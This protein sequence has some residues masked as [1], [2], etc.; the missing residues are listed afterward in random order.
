[1]PKLLSILMPVYNERPYLDRIVSR[2]LQAPLPEGVER[3]LVIVDDGSSDG[4]ADKL[5]ELEGRHPERVRVFHQPH[6][7]GKGAA[8]ARAVQEMRGDI[9]VFQDADL[10]YDPAEYGRLLEPILSGRA[11]VVYGSRFSTGGSRRVLNYH[12]ELGN[13]LLTHLSNATTGLNL[14]DMETCYKVFRADVL[15]TIPIRSQ[16]FGV[17]PEITAKI[18]KRN[19]A[20][21]EVPISYH[22]RKYAEGKKITWRDGL[23]ALYV[24]GKYWLL[25]DC[26][27]ERYGHYVLQSLST[28]R[29]FSAWMVSAIEPWLGHRILEI[30]SGIANISRLLP[31]RER[32]TLSDRDPE[33]LRL[34]RQA[35]EG[36]EGVDVVELDLDRDAHFERLER[37]YDT[38]VCLNVLEHVEDDAGAVRRMAS[39]LEPG[40][41]LVV[42]VPQHG[43]L[44]SEM[45]R[46]LGHV[47]RYDPG[48]LEALL[49]GAGLEVEAVSQFNAA[50]ILGWLVNARLL[51]RTRLD[52]LQL[53]AF[54]MLVPLLARV[55]HRLPLPGISAIGVGRKPQG[56]AR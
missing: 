31:R 45:D 15:R 3:E 27:D 17:E 19:C 13:K 21:Y 28:T 39:V 16:R 33:Y 35:F 6:N 22:G 41:R 34:L 11:D 9:A 29:R 38:V 43:F 37:R 56:A 52:S 18:A 44:M 48:A 7:M 42:L 50:A 36:A 54:D 24:I 12:H 46:A 30:G 2:V 5:D 14:S 23:E 55:E 25:D 47:R 32:L 51:G 53:K 10:E 8:L 26:F 40:G 49:G 20:V 1:M 4:S